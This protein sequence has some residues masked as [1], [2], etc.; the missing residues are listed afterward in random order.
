MLRIA[1]N[2]KTSSTSKIR[3]ITATKKNRR[4]KGVRD[5][6]FGVNPH[7]KGLSFSRSSK[8]FL[9][10]SI[11]NIKRI[12]L[13]RL[14]TIKNVINFIKFKIVVKTFFRWQW[15]IFIKLNPKIL[16]RN[17]IIYYYNVWN[18]MVYINL[19]PYKHQ[20]II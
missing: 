7:S 2:S 5:N 12:T 1:G 10:S 8:V 16:V 15:N 19:I 9:E 13:N 18:I 3:K 20:K 14:F 17:N 11:P 4:D 6:L